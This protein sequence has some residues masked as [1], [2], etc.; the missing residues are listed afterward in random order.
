MFLKQNGVEMEKLKDIS[1]RSNEGMGISS[2]EKCVSMPGTVDAYLLSFLN[3]LIYTDNCYSCKFATT[4][5][6]SDITLGD[7]WGTSLRDEMRKGVSLILVNTEKGGALI[8]EADIDLHDV[9]IDRA[10]AANAQLREPSYAPTKREWFMSQLEEGKNYNSLVRK[11]LP[12]Q[13]TRQVIKGWAIK[14]HLKKSG[15][16]YRLTF[17]KGSVEQDENT[18]SKYKYWLWRRK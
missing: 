9:D 17:E 18:V 4:D 5:R 6:I 10:I 15:G 16:G 11:A 14:L 12:K 3:A 2:R 13:Y 8:S 7:S 1:F